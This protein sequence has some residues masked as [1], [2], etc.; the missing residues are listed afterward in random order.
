MPGCAVVVGVLS[1]WVVVGGAV[2]VDVCPDGVVL[3]C[4]VVVGVVCPGGVVVGCA[5][6]V[7]V[8]CPG[9][10]VVGCVVVVDVCPGLVGVWVV[11]VWV[12]IRFGCAAARCGKVTTAAALAG[13]TAP[14]GIFVVLTVVREAPVGATKTTGPL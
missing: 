12:W 13:A 3:G 7:G 2:A 8:V 10:V 5:V 4:A 6:V 11:V 1:G 14:A 9:C